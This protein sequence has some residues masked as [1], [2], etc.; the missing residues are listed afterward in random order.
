[1][2]PIPDEEGEKALIDAGLPVGPIKMFS[3]TAKERRYRLF[4]AEEARI[5][6]LTAPAFNLEDHI[7]SIVRSEL[8]LRNEG[9]AS[10]K[11]KKKAKK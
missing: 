8:A 6:Q 10:K 4:L 7:R 3:E 2:N 11:K 1:M 5:E 9:K